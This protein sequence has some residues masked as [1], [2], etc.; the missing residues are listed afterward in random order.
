MSRTRGRSVR[1]GILIVDD[2]PQMTRALGLVV[3]DLSPVRTENGA[4]TA[5]AALASTRFCGLIVDVNLGG[6][7]GLDVLAFARAHDPP[8]PA[9]VLTGHAD[10]ALINR[11]FSLGASYACKPID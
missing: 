11:A 1:H 2:D 8:L 4:A 10:H 5:R 6:E 7:S 3:R 9:L